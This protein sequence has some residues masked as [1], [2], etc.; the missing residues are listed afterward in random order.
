M[1]FNPLSTIFQLYCC[2]QFYW[3]R[4]P[5]YTEKTPSL[6]QVTDKLGVGDDFVPLVLWY[7]TFCKFMLIMSLFFFFAVVIIIVNV[8]LLMLCI[9][10]VVAYCHIKVTIL[11]NKYS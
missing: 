6:P 7:C 9:V 3:R 5:E 2:G 11:N 1:V 10:V 4:K 8:V